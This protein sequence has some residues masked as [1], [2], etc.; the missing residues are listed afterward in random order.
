MGLLKGTFKSKGSSI[1]GMHGNQSGWFRGNYYDGDGNV[2]GVL[3]GHY[4]EQPRSAGFGFFQGRWRD[5]CNEEI[6]GAIADGL[7]E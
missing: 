4:H 3:R 1:N 6:A 2:L 5:Y 7:D